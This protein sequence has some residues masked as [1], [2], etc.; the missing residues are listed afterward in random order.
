MFLLV[1]SPKNKARKEE[2]KGRTSFKYPTVPSLKS[3]RENRKQRTS[4]WEAEGRLHGDSVAL[5]LAPSFAEEVCNAAQRRRCAQRPR[6][7]QYG[8]ALVVRRRVIRERSADGRQSGTCTVRRVQR[9]SRKKWEV[10]PRRCAWK[11]ARVC[12]RS[13]PFY[14]CFLKRKCLGCEPDGHTALLYG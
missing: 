11:A 12:R 14:I 1:K 5:G 6:S 9:M 7:S 4:S 3:P 13:S 2:K 8:R 10:V